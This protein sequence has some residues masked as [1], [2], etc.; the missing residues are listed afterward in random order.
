MARSAPEPKDH[1]PIR[2]VTTRAGVAYRVVMD[3]G[4]K[5]D[6]KRDQRT[7]TFRDDSPAKALAAARAW[8]AETRR[9]L[10]R[11]TLVR[12]SRIT[13]REL[14]DQYHDTRR[15][16]RVSTRAD[17]RSHLTYALKVFGDRQA[18]SL[19][20]AEVE[21]W[22]DQI[23][24][25]GKRNGGPLQVRSV[26]LALQTLRAVLEHGVDSGLLSVN[27]AAK[28]KP[29]RDSKINAPERTIWSPAEMNAFIRHADT[30]DLAAVWRLVCCG[31]S[32]SEIAG[33]RW[34]DIDLDAGVLTP[35]QGRT[36]VANGREVV[37]DDLKTARRY[38]SIAFESIHPRT[39]ALLRKLRSRQAA[40]QLAAGPAY[41]PTSDLIV[42]DALG[43]PVAPSHI[44]TMFHRVAA[45]AGVPKLAKIHD[46]RHSVATMLHQ[47]G[48]APANAATLLGHSIEQHLRVY[49]TQESR[50]AVTAAS[51]LGNVLRA[52]Q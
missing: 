18:Q 11:G 52:A 48:E 21:T 45:A 24:L 8:V 7:K 2:M 13:L 50:G 36:M 9:S 27:V 17:D 34:Q 26:E 43:Q 12:D 51:A 16:V 4:L 25:S 31:L 49:V 39:V 32:R 10:E 33:L 22:V 40:D 20:R 19:T 44:T 42:V 28:V 37:T 47:A 15:G 30:D 14:A 46:T 5:A 3:V 23:H 41:G 29:P 38:R 6:G 35:V 1:E